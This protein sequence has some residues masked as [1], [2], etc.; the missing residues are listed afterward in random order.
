MD[1]AHVGVRSLWPK[2]MSRLKWKSCAESFSVGRVRVTI[3]AAGRWDV[4]CIRSLLVLL[5]EAKDIRWSIGLEVSFN[6][7]LLVDLLWLFT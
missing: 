4:I 7:S 3:E 2:V 6:G 1:T 5:S